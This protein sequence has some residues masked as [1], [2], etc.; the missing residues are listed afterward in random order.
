MSLTSINRGDLVVVI[1]LQNMS[2]IFTVAITALLLRR[3]ER[4]TRGVVVGVVFVAGGAA[5]V[6]F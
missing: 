2:P 4:V 5:L 3:L 6:N 1:P